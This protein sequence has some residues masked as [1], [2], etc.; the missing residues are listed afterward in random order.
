MANKYAVVRTD[1]M[2][3]TDVRS[4]L[5]SLKYMGAAGSTPTAIQN[6]SV[7]LLDGLLDS[8]REIYKAKDIVTGSETLKE[9]VL[10]DSPEVNSYSFRSQ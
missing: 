5:V 2:S 9:I 4:G 10:V 8:E 3:G 7:V 6:G 1:L